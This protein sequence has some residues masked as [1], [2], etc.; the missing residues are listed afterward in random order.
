MY[1]LSM[2]IWGSE[3]HM[4]ETWCQQGVNIVES[5]L[6]STLL[7]VNCIHNINSCVRFMGCF[8]CERCNMTSMHKRSTR[9]VATFK[10]P[11]CKRCI[12][13][14]LHHPAYLW[15]HIIQHTCDVTV[16]ERE[17]FP[18]LCDPNRSQYLASSFRFIIAPIRPMSKAKMLLVVPSQFAFL[19]ARIKKPITIVNCYH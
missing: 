19:V 18:I 8:T 10:K 4:F 15:R 3:G 17:G 11:V 12:V 14:Q 1:A 16:N 9:V 2:K 13:I 7:L 6:K 5:P